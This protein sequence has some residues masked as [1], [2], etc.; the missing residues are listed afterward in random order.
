M[1]IELADQQYLRAAHGY[2]ELEMYSEAAAE[3]DG[4]VRGAASEAGR[5]EQIRSQTFAFCL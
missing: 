5:G 3:L 2:L 1:P 4:H